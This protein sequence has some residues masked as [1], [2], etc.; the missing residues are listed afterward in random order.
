M[1]DH[2]ASQAFF[3]HFD[4]YISVLRQIDP[5]N[6]LMRSTCPKV[7]KIHREAWRLCSNECGSNI[8]SVIR[9]TIRHSKYS[10]CNRF[11]PLKPC[12]DRKLNSHHGLSC[13]NFWKDLRSDE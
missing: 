1:F 11:G 2:G 13:I 6:G 12:S 10:L 7:N 8:D 9:D 5:N 4:T 3:K